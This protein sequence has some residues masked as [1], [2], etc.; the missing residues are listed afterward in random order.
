MYYKNIRQICKNLLPNSVQIRF[1]SKKAPN[2]LSSF[3]KNYKINDVFEKHG[4]Y[5]IPC[6]NC[7]LKYIGQTG[8]SLYIRTNEHQNSTTDS[9]KVTSAIS[10]HSKIEKHTFDFKNIKLLLYENSGIKRKIGEAIL[11]KR[12]NT[13]PDNISSFDLK[14]Y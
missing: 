9:S 6:K 1:Y 12:S 10:K 8:R 14:L 4:I 3:S 5:S 7:E 13:I 2:L 11:I